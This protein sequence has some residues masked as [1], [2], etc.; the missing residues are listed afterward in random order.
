MKLIATLLLA[1]V[2]LTGCASSGKRINTNYVSQI[3][4]GETTEQDIRANLGNP[5]AASVTQDGKKMIVYSFARTEMKAATFIPIVG[6][7]AGGANTETETLQVWF[8][9]SGVVTSHSFNQGNID[10]SSGLTAK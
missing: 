1:L 3:K 2:F 6:L 10:S 9:D 4:T 5:M 8:D 7:F